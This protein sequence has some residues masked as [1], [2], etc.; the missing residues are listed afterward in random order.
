MTA[1]R[2]HFTPET[3]HVVAGTFLRLRITSVNGTHGFK[4]AGLGI[5]E[6]LTENE[7][8][9]VKVYLGEKGEYPFSCSHFCGLGHF[10]MK[11]VSA[12]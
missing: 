7:P 5:D 1:Q 8:M 2:F 10:G 6:H 12:R 9:M 11:R 3:I 4:L